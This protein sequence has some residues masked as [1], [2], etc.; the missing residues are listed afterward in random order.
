LAKAKKWLSVKCPKCGLPAKR[1]TD[2]MPNWA[3]SNWYFLRYCDPKNEKSFV[4]KKLLE[5]WLPVDWYNGGMEHT[6][7][8]LL[9]SRF[10]YK[11]LYDLGL[12]PADEPYKKR[13]SHG[14]ILGDGGIKMSK[15]KGNVINPDTI[16]K[17]EGADT[18]RIYE[19]FMG[20]F[21]QATS[22]DKK[23]INGT[24]RFLDKVWQLSN[25]FIS[26]NP[27]ESAKISGLKKNYTGP[28]KKFLRILKI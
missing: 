16:V 9:Y 26:I 13:T 21:A 10:C 12:V 14:M 28:L 18:L 8:H 2:T 11:V 22:W 1:E 24:R 23:G 27:S 17:E 6:T 5:Y 25:Q 20:P 19:M 4:S 3:G 7:L 15:S